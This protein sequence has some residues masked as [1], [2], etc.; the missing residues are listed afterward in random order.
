VNQQSDIFYQHHAT[1][2]RDL[3]K[4]QLQVGGSPSR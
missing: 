1:T 2:Y 4:Q 3:I